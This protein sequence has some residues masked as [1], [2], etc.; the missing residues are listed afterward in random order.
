MLQKNSTKKETSAPEVIV[1]KVRPPLVRAKV[2]AAHF[3]VHPRTVRLWAESGAI[4]VVR[5]GGSIRFD[6]EAVAEFL[7]A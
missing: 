4:P 2:I 3:G 1:D 5:I 6:F 7:N